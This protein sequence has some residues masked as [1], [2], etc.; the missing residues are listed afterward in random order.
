MSLKEKILSAPEPNLALQPVEVPEWGATVFMQGWS[1]K[2]RERFEKEFGD[3][4]EAGENVRAKVLVRV[5]KDEAGNRIFDDSDAD[6]LGSKIA[7]PLGRLFVK[8]M[9]LSGLREVDA[10]TAKKN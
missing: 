8:V 1:G 7:G 9:D 4:G 5:L 2:E 6:A 3:L 10:E